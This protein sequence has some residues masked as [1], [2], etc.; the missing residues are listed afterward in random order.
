MVT[1]DSIRGVDWNSSNTSTPAN[2]AGVRV[3]L[4]IMGMTGFYWMVVQ[5]TFYDYASSQDKTLVFVEG[6]SHGATPCRACKST[7]GEFG[8]TVKRAFD[9]AADWLRDRF[10]P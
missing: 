10:V 1:E 2:L 7:P 5:E 3:P 9:Y 8:D 4:L 6:A